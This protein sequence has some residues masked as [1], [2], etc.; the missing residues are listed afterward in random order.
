M[1]YDIEMART[2]GAAG[3][4]FGVLRTDA[5]I[6]RDQTGAL[7]EL[8]RPMSVTF[9]KAF[10]Q[11]PDPEQALEALDRPGRR[12]RAHLGRPPTALEGMETLKRLVEQA[13]GRIAILAGGRLSP[14]NLETYHRRDGRARGPPRLGREPDDGRIDDDRSARWFRGRLER[15]RRGEGSRDC[16]PDQ[17]AEPTRV[18]GSLALG[19]VFLLPIDVRLRAPQVGEQVADLLLAQVLEQALGHE[20]GLVGFISSM[21]SRGQ[22]QLL[23]V[24]AAEDDDVLVLSTTTPVRVRPSVVATIVPA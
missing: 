5:T 2:L 22:G 19:G 15:G 9:H 23:A 10:D 4:V 7:V 13:R 6:D 8:A 21:A 16:R 17:A 24:A 18:R 14:T 3:V 11:T 12:S 20:R 1:R